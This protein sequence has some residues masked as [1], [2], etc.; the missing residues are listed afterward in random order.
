M[1]KYAKLINGVWQINPHVI[2]YN[3]RTYQNPKARHYLA[4]GFLPVLEAQMPNPFYDE[5]GDILY[6]TAYE[7]GSGEQEGYVVQ[8]YVPV[9]NY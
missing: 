3:G 4:G 1:T 6:V 2:S 5:N 9:E 7:Y 8:S